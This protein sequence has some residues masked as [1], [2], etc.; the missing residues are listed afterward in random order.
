[1]HFTCSNTNI[2][3]RAAQLLKVLVVSVACSVMSWNAIATEDAP[4]VEKIDPEANAQPNAQPKPLRIEDLFIAINA[5]GWNRAI[6]IGHALDKKTSEPFLADFARATALV[7]HGKCE[8][9][10][11]LA[12]KVVYI[13]SDFLPAYDL[14]GICL[15]AEGKAVSAAK[16]YKNIANKMDDGPDKELL[17]ARA[18]AVAPDM[19]FQYFVDLDVTPSTNAN[20]ATFER[21]IGQGV[22]S[23][24]SR[25][26]S[27]VTTRLSGTISKP[28]YATDKM[29]ASIALRI[30]ASHTSYNDAIFPFARISA[31]T[32]YLID[33]SSTMSGSVFH[34]YTLYDGKHYLDQTGVR[35]NY[36]R[37]IAAGFSA[38]ASG[39]VTYYNYDNE[40]RSGFGVDASVSVTKYVRPQD[41]VNVSVSA[42]KQ[43]R[44]SD[45]YSY[46][47]G[48]VGLEWEHR[49]KTGFITSLG[50]GG[51]IRRYD[52][53]APLTEEEQVNKQVY[54]RVGVSHKKVSYKN[55][56]PEL[57]YTATRQWSNDVFSRY[58]AHDVGIRVK[59]AF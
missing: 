26:K 41:R 36:G 32:R 2:M 28:V 49:F 46:I 18:E 57:T 15:K 39:G 37:Q 38:G 30:G 29:Q 55:M 3:K 44:K 21:R 20:R 24:N 53:D 42:V 9:G 31:N 43:I 59:G 13:N 58:I 45:R 27:G 22:I 54:A 7:F 4:A 51:S 16:L 33:K 48:S 6:R 50:A 10:Q 17:L 34:E 5:K 14:I 12:R 40:P 35:V 47:E 23:E 11:P 56:R 52:A 1:M 8:Q 19:S 25:E